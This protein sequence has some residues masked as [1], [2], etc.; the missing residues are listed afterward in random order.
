M[1]SKE[2]GSETD[3]D[4][5]SKGAVTPPR[6]DRTTLVVWFTFFLALVLLVAFNMQ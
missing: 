2:N 1:Q 3:L 6:R 4:H 5:T